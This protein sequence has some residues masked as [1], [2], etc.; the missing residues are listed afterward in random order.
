MSSGNAYERLFK[1]I[2]N[3]GKLV[4]DGKRDPLEV[5][6]VLQVII[7]QKRLEKVLQPGYL[8]NIEETEAQKS[9]R[10]IMGRNFLGIPESCEHF[11]ITPNRQFL[12]VLGEIPFSEDVLRVCYHSH[13]LVADFG[14]SILQVRKRVDRDLFYSHEDAQYNDKDF[15]NYREQ[16]CWRLIRKDMVPGYDDPCYRKL[17]YKELRSCLLTDKEEVP[18]PRQMVYAIILNYLATGERMFKYA[19][20]ITSTTESCDDDSLNLVGHFDSEGLNIDDRLSEHFVMVSAW[21][22][23][24]DKLRTGS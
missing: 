21:K 16:P 4:V 2:A 18:K 5:S 17:S 12:E 6:R 23:S 19:Y 1:Q 11:S 22:R 15:A 24:F 8:V 9:A 20:A 13:V 14:L 3:I 10:Q 7:D